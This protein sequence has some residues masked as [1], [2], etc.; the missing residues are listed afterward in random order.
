MAVL[1]TPGSPISTGLFLVR[2]AST[3]MVRRISSSRPM[4]GSSLPSRAACGEVARVFLERVIALLGRRGIGGAAL[5]QIVDGLV[6]GL[7]VDARL[8]APRPPRCRRHGEREQ[9]RSAVTKE[10][11]AFFAIFSAWSKSRAVSGASRAGRRRHLP[12]WAAWRARPRLRG[13]RH[14]IA[15]GRADQVGREALRRRAGLSEYGRAESADGRTEGPAS[16]RFAENRER[17]RY[18]SLGSSLYPFITRPRHAAGE[19]ADPRKGGVRC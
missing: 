19:R 13:A 2:R 5:A 16:G 4:T 3:W 10:S 9:Q 17:V 7:G 14:G 15:A 12:P 1:P 8:A 11:P 18:T 6:Q